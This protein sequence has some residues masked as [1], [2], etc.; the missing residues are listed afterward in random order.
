[1]SIAELM[2]SR[3]E[4]LER[5]LKDTDIVDYIDY[6]ECGQMVSDGHISAVLEKA[7][8]EIIT[9]R[10]TIERMRRQK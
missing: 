9:L 7:K 4:E 10:L 8:S 2:K 3:F 6:V 5:L 1:M